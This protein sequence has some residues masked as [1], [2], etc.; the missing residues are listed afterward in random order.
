MNAIINPL[1][2]QRLERWLRE[3]DGCRTFDDLMIAIHKGD[4]QSHAFGDTWVL[5]SVVDFPQRRAVHIDLVVGHAEDAV[6]I[7]PKICEWARSI[8]ADLITANG[9]PGWDPFRNV[10]EGW[11]MKGYLYSKDLRDG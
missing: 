7:E 5:T 9:R 2:Q 8:R 1:M 10:V 11:R 4:L 6:K 3:D